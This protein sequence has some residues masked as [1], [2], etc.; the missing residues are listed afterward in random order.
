MFEKWP[1]VPGAAC[2]PLRQSGGKGGPSDAI[3]PA[4]FS[5]WKGRVSVA[6]TAAGRPTDRDSENK[7]YAIGTLAK[8]VSYISDGKRI[9]PTTLHLPIVS[10]SHGVTV[11]YTPFDSSPPLT[12][13]VSSGG[14]E[15]THSRLCPDGITLFFTACFSSLFGASPQDNNHAFAQLVSLSNC[16]CGNSNRERLAPLPSQDNF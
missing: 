7:H 1:W 6:I 15:D 16:R 2:L 5:A 10:T 8:N 11:L 9:C 14:N 4:R 12:V 3:R 13:A